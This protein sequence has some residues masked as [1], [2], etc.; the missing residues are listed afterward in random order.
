LIIALRLLSTLAGRLSAVIFTAPPH[1]GRMSTLETFGTL[2]ENVE[3]TVSL[4]VT[5]REQLSDDDWDILNE[6]PLLSQLLDSLSDLE[7]TIAD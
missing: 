1:H 5:L 2:L 6:S 7:Y 4:F 3:T